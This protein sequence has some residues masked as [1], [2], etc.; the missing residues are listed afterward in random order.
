MTENIK[1]TATD[2]TEE[3]EKWLFINSE[4]KRGYMEGQIN[5]IKEFAGFL[6]S[7]VAKYNSICVSHR[8]EIVKQPLPSHNRKG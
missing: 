5:T 4:Y 3:N 7:L 2:I 1:T 8:L 6:D